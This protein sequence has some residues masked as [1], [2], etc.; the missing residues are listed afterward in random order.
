[1]TIAAGP[2]KHLRLALIAGRALLVGNM[3]CYG[4]VVGPRA[5]SY[6]ALESAAGTLDHDLVEAGQRQSALDA[7]AKR[8]AATEEN[9]GRFRKEI[10]GSKQEKSIEI[11][12]EIA[13]IS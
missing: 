12:R 1:M 7:Y 5:K 3:I 8:L 9:V 11:Q 2:R 6:A 10:L 4:L 13:Q